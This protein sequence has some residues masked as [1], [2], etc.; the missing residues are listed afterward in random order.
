MVMSIS[1]YVFISCSLKS[2]QSLSWIKLNLFQLKYKCL[3]RKQVLCARPK[4]RFYGGDK[5][6]Q[7]LFL[8][9]KFVWC[10]CSYIKSCLAL[11]DPMGCSPPGSS[12]YGIFQARIP[13]WVAISFSRGSS[14]PTDLILVSWQVNSLLLSHL[15]GLVGQVKVI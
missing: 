14:R 12:V 4:A 15:G 2:T 6:A 3:L 5:E 13:E 7:S 1:R 10:V 8:S 11:G 9:Q